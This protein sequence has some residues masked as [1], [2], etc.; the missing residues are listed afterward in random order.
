MAQTC[1]AGSERCLFVF[2]GTNFT[3]WAIANRIIIF[4]AGAISA[5][6]VTMFVIGTLMITLSGIKEE[7]R[8]KGKDLMIGSILALAIVAGAYA[9]LQTVDFFLS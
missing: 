4:L 8:Q 6:S 9:L 7:Y 2:T 5:I 3:F 1:P